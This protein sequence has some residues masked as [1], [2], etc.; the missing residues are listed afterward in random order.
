M[1]PHGAPI[2][3]NELAAA[4][5]VS[6]EWVLVFRLYDELLWQIATGSREEL[7]AL[8]QTFWVADYPRIPIPLMVVAWRILGLESPADRE[9]LEACIA[10][11]SIHCDPVQEEKSLGHLRA[12]LAQATV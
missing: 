4:L 10:S 11:I 6:S 7:A 5:S 1:K 3:A 9:Q 8:T 12:L 2:T